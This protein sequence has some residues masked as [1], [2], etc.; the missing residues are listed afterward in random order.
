MDLYFQYADGREELCEENVDEENAVTAA[1]R[2]LSK[3]NP[4][5][6]SYYQRTWKDNLGNLWIDVGSHTEFYILKASD[7]RH[8]NH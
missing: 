8:A 4:R 5:Y 3:R 7:N 6:F 2:D 1:L